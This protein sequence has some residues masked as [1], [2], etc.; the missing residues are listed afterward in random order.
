MSYQANNASID[1]NRKLSAPMHGFTENHIRVEVES[2]DW[3]DNQV[4][5][6]AAWR[7]WGERMMTTPKV[8][9]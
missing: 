6:A 1:E 9:F 8:Q 5:N 2:D 7:L 4:V 3:L